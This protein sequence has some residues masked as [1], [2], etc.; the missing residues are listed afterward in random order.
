MKLNL[1][2]SLSKYYCSSVEM[3][4]EKLLLN[5]ESGKGANVILHNTRVFKKYLLDDEYAKLSKDATYLLADGVPISWL[6]KLHGFSDI[7]H[8]RGI[9][10]FRKLMSKIN[11]K[12]PNAKICMIVSTEKI[13]VE[14]IKKMKSEYPA[15]DN[16][17]ILVAPWGNAQ[18]IAE[19][20]YNKIEI[21]QPEFVW[22]CLGAPKQDEVGNLLRRK[23]ASLITISVGVVAEYFAGLVKPAPKIFV[24]L[25]LEWLFRWIIKP[26][27]TANFIFP[28]I[29][30]SLLLILSMPIYISRKI[31]N[32]NS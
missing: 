14:L 5:S 20:V 21:F 8:I 9:F 25:K 7:V 31:F 24:N 1:Q 16:V 23:C 12:K 3:L 15:I 18:E 22:V 19:H 10:L 30:M 26:E 13:K 27:R 17:Q 29:T 32:F 28:F 4:I 6:G 11:N 2:E